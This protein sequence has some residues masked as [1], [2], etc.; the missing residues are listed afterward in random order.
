MMDTW[1]DNYLIYDGLIVKQPLLRESLQ[2]VLG[3]VSVGHNKLTSYSGSTE[4]T[5]ADSVDSQ[6][7]PLRFIGPFSSIRC[8]LDM[9]LGLKERGR[10]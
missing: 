3:L 10:P 7:Y 4:L 6:T 5:L 1:I 8:P 9:F 2:E